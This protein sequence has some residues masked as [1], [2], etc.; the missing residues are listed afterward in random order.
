MGYGEQREWVITFSGGSIKHQ[1]RAQILLQTPDTSGGFYHKLM[2]WKLENRKYMQKS[3]WLKGILLLRQKIS[4][5]IELSHQM[6]DREGRWVCYEGK[7]R[8]LVIDLN[9]GHP[10]G[11]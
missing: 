9:K 5:Q 2:E 11:W 6:D 1:K 4:P 3:G 10:D 7:K 8:P